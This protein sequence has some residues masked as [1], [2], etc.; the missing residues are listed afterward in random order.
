MV[1]NGIS[2]AIVGKI[3]ARKLRTKKMPELRASG[4]FNL[5]IID[6]RLC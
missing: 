4:I 6:S 3:L 2:V 5:A 1:G